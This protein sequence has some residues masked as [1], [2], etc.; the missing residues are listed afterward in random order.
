MKN[1]QNIAARTY[2]LLALETHG[3]QTDPHT[4]YVTLRP[5]TE[6]LTISDVLRF[7]VT[8]NVKK[9]IDITA[10]NTTLTDAMDRATWWAHV[11][12]E[13]HIRQ[14][15]ENSDWNLTVDP[16]YIK[17]AQLAAPGEW[18]IM[19]SV[20]CGKIPDPN[21]RVHLHLHLAVPVI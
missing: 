1:S 3:G 8:R 21:R 7:A 11:T 13:A 20:D 6:E 17:N 16:E 18:A 9:I 5:P 14:F 2:L 19:D 4:R 15:I 12:I 10:T